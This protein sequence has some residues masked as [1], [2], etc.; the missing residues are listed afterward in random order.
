VTELGWFDLGT[1]DVNRYQGE[2]DDNAD[3][4]EDED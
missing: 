4:D 1:S 2:V 3:A